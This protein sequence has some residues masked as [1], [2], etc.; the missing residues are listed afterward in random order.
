M[1]D[2]L[3]VSHDCVDV[4]IVIT[5]IGIAA[6]LGRVWPTPML[7]EGLFALGSHDHDIDDKFYGTPLVMPVRA[8]GVNG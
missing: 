3:L 8:R 5:P 1:G 6:P 2:D 7:T 4:G